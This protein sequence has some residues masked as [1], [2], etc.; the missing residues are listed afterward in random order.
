MS[1]SI[2]ASVEQA[3]NNKMR[4]LSDFNICGRHDKNMRNKLKK[5]ISEKPNKDPREVLDY[6]CRPMIQDMVNSWDLDEENAYE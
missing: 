6:F 1:N 4:V 2:K 3:I 5:A